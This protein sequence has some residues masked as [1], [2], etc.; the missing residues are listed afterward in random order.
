MEE[1]PHPLDVR[2]EASIQVEVPAVNPTE[3]TPT[4]SRQD[5]PIDSSAM[6]GEE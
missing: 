1:S 2:Q 3:S 4:P 5:E 6:D